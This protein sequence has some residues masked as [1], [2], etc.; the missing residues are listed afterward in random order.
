MSTTSR[1]KQVLRPA[2]TLVIGAVDRRLSDLASD[3][4]PAVVAVHVVAAEADA[5]A[6][7]KATAGAPA[8]A[9]AMTSGRTSVGIRAMFLIEVLL[10]DSTKDVRGARLV[11]KAGANRGLRDSHRTAT[12][13]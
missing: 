11:D 6:G 3:P 8:I 2:R 13:C 1:S 10:P 7:A 12:G 9:S 5:G 4:Q